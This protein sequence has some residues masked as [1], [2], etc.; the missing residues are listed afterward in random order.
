MLSG[1]DVGSLTDVGRLAEVGLRLINS[2][3]SDESDDF[4]VNDQGT[5]A[6]SNFFPPIEIWK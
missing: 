2:S 4:V 5:P 6:L 1:F 3:R